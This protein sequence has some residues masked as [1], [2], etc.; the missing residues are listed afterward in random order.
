MRIG[1]VLLVQR[2]ISARCSVFTYKYDSG[3]GVQK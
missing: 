1:G 2:R 3:F